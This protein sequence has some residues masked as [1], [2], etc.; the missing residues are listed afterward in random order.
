MQIFE[1]WVNALVSIVWGEF[2]L[3]PL[4]AAVGLYLTVGLRAVPWRYLPYAIKLLREPRERAAGGEI[5]P[6]QALMTA[7][8]ATIGTGNIAGVATAI[9]LGGPGAIFWMWLIAFVGMATKFSE[10]VLAVKFR[11][12]DATGQYVGGPMYYI[13]NGLG[14]RFRWLG[15]AFALFGMIAAFGIG[16]MVQSNSVANALASQYTIAPWITG[17]L[18]AIVT[19][20]VVL[21]GVRRIGEVAARIV[22]LMAVLYVLAAITVLTINGGAIPGAFELIITSAFQ[23]SAATGGFAGATVWMAIR[24]GVARGIFSNE[25]GLGSAAIAHA[26][27]RTTEPVRQGMVAMLG[28]FIDTIIVCTLTALVILVS[29]AW[30]SGATGASL[31]NAAFTHTLGS[32]GGD[33]V[34]VGIAVFAFTTIIGWS[35]YG[36]RC[37]AFLF[38][39]RCIPYYR[40][41]WGRRGVARGGLQTRFGVGFRR[42]VQRP[43]GDTESHRADSTEPSRVRGNAPLFSS[44]GRYW[45]LSQRDASTM[46]QPDDILAV[47]RNALHEDLGSG[48]VTA[49]LIDE[50]AVATATIVCREEAV[51]CGAAWAEA[52]F[53]EVDPRIVCAWECRD[54]DALKPDSIVCRV[55][56]PARGLVTA[57]RTALNLLQTLSG[58][59][60]TVRRYA[61]ELA[62]TRTTLLDTRKTIP[63]LRQ[64]Q[65]YAVRCG[66]G[67]NHRIGLY[68][69]ILIKENHIAAAGSI[70]AAITRMR[71][72][73]PDLTLECEVE[74]I[75]DAERALMAGAD[76][77]LLDNFTLPMLAEAVRITAGRVKLE[78]SGGFEFG[79]L[80]DVA[81]TG[82]DF[83]SVGAITKHLTATDFSMRFQ[84]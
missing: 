41:L 52:A 11:E 55:Q 77:L 37:A 51:L 47:V 43:H 9:F 59:A 82:V 78:A 58:T 22:P 32:V 17:G 46:E 5:S 15:T 18:L 45:P 72:R 61:A 30:D 64:A 54:G 6:F 62:G 83:V 84:T 26:A 21:G 29:G 70:E 53:A 12:T 74:N 35:Y 69:G 4:L 57:E 8:S 7:L 56:G 38:G 13:R 81:A 65:K 71:E 42:P 48:D 50:T 63:G 24:W 44:S 33:I 36:E 68:D 76:M 25:S 19:A 60:S 14:R 1:Q 34:S 10:A 66:G 31:T 75:P 16:N 49:T 73:F 80:R 67:A 40:C 28:T 23:G 39:T 27:A 3:I 2:V 20:F 79:E